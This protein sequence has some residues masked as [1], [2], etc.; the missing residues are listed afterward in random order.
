METLVGHE[1]FHPKE[2]G[3]TPTFGLPFSE[4]WGLEKEIQYWNQGSGAKPAPPYFV[5]EATQM[6]KG[7]SAFCFEL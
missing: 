1:K 6:T 3:S 4:T 5:T 7:N 2:S